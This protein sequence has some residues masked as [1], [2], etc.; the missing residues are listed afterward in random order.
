L[1]GWRAET[2]SPVA[3]FYANELLSIFDGSRVPILAR[4]YIEAQ[5]EMD[6]GKPEAMIVFWNSTLGLPWEYR[7]DLPEEEELRKRAEKYSEWSVPSG[8]LVPLLTVDVQHDRLALTCWVM[9]RGEEMWL[10][11][12]GEVY[13]QTVVAHQGAWLELEQLLNKEVMTPAGVGIRIA[14]CGIDCSDGQTSEASYAFVRKHDRGVNRPVLAL[15]GASDSEGRVEIW[16]PPKAIDPNRKATKASK[17]G[18]QVHIVGTAKAKDLI[19][20]W[21]QEGGRVRLAGN[22]AGR[23]HWYENVRADFYEQMLSEIKIPNRLNPRRRSWKAR[24]DRRNEALDCTVYAVYLSRH[25]RLHLRRP[26]QWDLDEI[27]LRQG[28]LLPAAV[29]V[30]KSPETDHIVEP[31][32]MVQTSAPVANDSGSPESSPETT[33]T[34][35]DIMAASRAKQAWEAMMR[36]RKGMRRG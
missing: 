2:K 7:G 20:G 4:K 29:D 31:D 16:T 24:T 32:E 8:A 1:H 11:Y 14:A 5:H 25:L 12:W 17:F 10:A 6:D 33:S 21:A 28:V 35:E 18:V 22:G 23:M 13:G 19:L 9:G 26:G 30:P 36:Q 34:A 15:K 3:G 27:R